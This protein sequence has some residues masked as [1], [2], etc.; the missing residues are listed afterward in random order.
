MSEAKELKMGVDGPDPTEEEKK[1]RIAGMKAT[2]EK[3]MP[4]FAKGVEGAKKDM[5]KHSPQIVIHQDAFAAGYD[6]DEYII[7]GMAVK[8]AGLAGVEVHFIGK[9]HETF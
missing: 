5:D 7:L 8:Y 6:G 3:Y 9:N 2:V 1:E 4:D